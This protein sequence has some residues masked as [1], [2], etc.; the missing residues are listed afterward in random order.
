MKS[1]LMGIFGAVLISVFTDM[2]LPE[3]WSKYIK[4]ITGLIIISTI[5]APL[6]KTINFDFEKHFEVPKNIEFDAEEYSLSL[7]KEE[8]EKT[9]SN[10][11]S[12]RMMDEFNKEITAE[13]EVS[14][15]TENKISG[16]QTINLIG[17]VNNLMVNR[18]NEIYAPREV[19]INGF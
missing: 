7:V 2:I 15:N 12:Q 16:I 4:I 19:M 14:V 3:K 6:G 1:Y 10:D 13:V 11:I 9:V 5:A 18:I 8:F 17:D